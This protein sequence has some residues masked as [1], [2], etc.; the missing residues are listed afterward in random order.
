MMCKESL[1]TGKV[2][3]NLGEARAKT[4]NRSSKQRGDHIVTYAGQEVHAKCRL[5]YINGKEIQIHLKNNRLC[6]DDP[7]PSRRS[8]QP[9]YDP[10]I[11]YLF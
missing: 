3:L 1:G 10:R 11:H 4:V 6:T 7:G 8:F 2:T 5:D 9:A